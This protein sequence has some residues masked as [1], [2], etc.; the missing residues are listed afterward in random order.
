MILDRS[1]GIIF[2]ENTPILVYDYIYK[3]M[4]IRN[5][6]IEAIKSFQYHEMKDDE[7]KSKTDLEKIAQYVSAYDG[8]WDLK[9]LK[10]AF[11]HICKFNDKIFIDLH[12]TIGEKT[13]L[14]PL[15]V[16]ILMIYKICL[17][18]SIDVKK[19]DTITTMNDKIK[20]R[21]AKSQYTQTEVV[22]TK[23]FSTQ[24]DAV[25]E[26][27]EEEKEE[28]EHE[29]ENKDISYFIYKSKLNEKESIEA[30][31]DVFDLDITSSSSPVREIKELAKHG[32]KKYVPVDPVFRKWYK[33]NKSF[34]NV[35]KFYK[36]YFNDKYTP[37]D[38]TD[39]L[40]ME[41]LHFGGKDD[42]Y[43]RVLNKNFYNGKIPGI[44][45][46]T[47]AYHEPLEEAGDCISYGSIE[48]KEMA[49]FTIEELIQY[50]K[51][52]DAFVDPL[53]EGLISDEAM[54]KL[55][56][57][58]SGTFSDTYEELQRV[59][60]V[61]ENKNKIKSKS[62]NN[63]QLEACDDSKK[64]NFSK[65]F[66][67]LF[68]LGMYM[69]GWKV[70]DTDDFP[71]TS[72]MCNKASEEMD[73]IEK[74][75]NEC[76]QRLTELISEFS[77]KEKSVINALPLI[78]INGQRNIYISNNEQEGLTVSDRLK[79]IFK[80]TDNIHSCI[81]M[82]SNYLISSANYYLKFMVGEELLDI[83]TLDLIS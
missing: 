64:T 52:K 19:D 24:T 65:Y 67:I 41:G 71:L 31:Y 26:V 37:N 55:G 75:I 59:I 74:N 10:Q 35:K 47:V 49:V 57:I 1:K 17:R 60:D 7:K 16:D 69:R 9:S 22:E 50:F 29:F 28:E 56:I 48:N 61:I 70:D 15:N 81:R 46:K 42:L 2:N 3:I 40:S 78:K 32:K 72:E 21:L 44:V 20:C 51:S 58:C 76:H 36:P 23:E 13:P 43:M 63:L 8:E 54:D 4:R 12:Y 6:S 45:D 14:T 18:M 62:I 5:G 27:V 25:E 79:I 11:K 33:I 53:S 77:E 34:Y 83:K 38:V 80:D 30:A 68:E 66:R 39:L 82:S 73:K